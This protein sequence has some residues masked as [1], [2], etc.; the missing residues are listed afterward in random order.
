M[1]IITVKGV[2]QAA[3]TWTISNHVFKTNTLD[4]FSQSVSSQW[5]KLT[6]KFM[7]THLAV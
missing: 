2:T 4:D 5:H 7:I 6:K 1:I 3:C